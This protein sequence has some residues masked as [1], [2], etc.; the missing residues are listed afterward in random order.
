M[1][2]D[3]LICACKADRNRRPTGLGEGERQ[4]RR[5]LLCSAGSV[6]VCVS[7]KVAA[8]PGVRTPPLAPA[9]SPSVLSHSHLLR[10]WHWQQGAASLSFRRRHR[11]AG[12]S[13]PSTPLH[14][15]T[16]PSCWSGTPAGRRTRLMHSTMSRGASFLARGSRT[17]LLALPATRVLC[18]V[19]WCDTRNA[20]YSCAFSSRC[21]VFL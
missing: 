2:K 20:T 5:A 17:T 12:S 16:T 3:N 21:F 7:A 9:S 4:K 14:Y 8:P 19:V 11:P 10:Q 18:G 15:T 1:D 6:R 13:D